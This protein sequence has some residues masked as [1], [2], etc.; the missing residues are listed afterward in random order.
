VPTCP[1]QWS[2]VDLYDQ[3]YQL[4]INVKDRNGKTASKTLQVVPRCAEPA[5]EVECRCICKAGYVLGETC[6]GSDAGADTGGSADAG[7][8]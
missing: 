8:D 6:T 1:N 5:N 4:E 7:S 3:T 2:S